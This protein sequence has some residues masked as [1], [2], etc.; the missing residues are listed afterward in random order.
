MP[1]KLNNNIRLAFIFSINRIN[2]LYNESTTILY[3]NPLFT[4]PA[5]SHS[6]M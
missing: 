6:E 2:Y 1:E 5:G 4:T 3:I